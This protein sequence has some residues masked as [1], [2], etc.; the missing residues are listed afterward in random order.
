M[1][2][3]PITSRHP[4][5]LSE[6]E[7]ARAGVAIAR[8]LWEDALLHLRRS[9]DFRAESGSS[10]V[11]ARL[12][13]I[14]AQILVGHVDDALREGEALLT[15]LR[16]TR[17]A[18]RVAW[19]QILLVAAWL[20]KGEPAPAR[21]LL[22]EAWPQMPLYRVTELLASHAV[23]LAALEDRP[24]CGGPVGRLDADALYAAQDESRQDN[25]T[26]SV[27][28]ALAIVRG[29]LAPADIERLKTAGAALGHE[30]ARQVALERP[31]CRPEVLP[32]A[33]GGM[34]PRPSRCPETC[35]APFR[36]LKDASSLTFSMLKDSPRGAAPTLEPSNRQQSR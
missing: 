11:I 6:G 10:D 24:R 21:V 33:R 27:D 8:Q 19:T 31:T 34:P 29:A 28:R 18:S 1:E 13:V 26:A 14:E 32:S 15:R 4:Y 23:L 7:Q 22:A 16:G 20:R 17:W 35:R 9:A 30:A 12:N 2:Q 25:E 3:V 36:T 5:L